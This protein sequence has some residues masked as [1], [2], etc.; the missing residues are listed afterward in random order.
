[1]LTDIYVNTR[2][3]NKMSYKVIIELD[4]DT[5]PSPKEVIKYINELGEEINYDLINNKKKKKVE[6]LI[7]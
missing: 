7:L 4:F 2:K 6:R 3:E 5:K 1:M